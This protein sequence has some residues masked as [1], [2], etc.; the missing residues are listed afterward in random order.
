MCVSVVANIHVKMSHDN[1]VGALTPFSSPRQRILQFLEHFQSTS[2]FSH[3]V[4]V[5]FLHLLH[6]CY[7]WA[8][9][10]SE[11]W[12][13]NLCYLSLHSPERLYAYPTVCGFS[14]LL[15]I[16][17]Y[18]PTLLFFFSAY[19]PFACCL[20]VSHTS[21]SS[22]CSAHSKLHCLWSV[23]GVDYCIPVSELL[24]CTEVMC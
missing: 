15:H 24:N 18:T 11:F 9:D 10:S 7:F 23:Q 22:N 12:H 3:W 1:S 2:D 4:S 13:R 16:T 8:I 14:L 19:F 17:Q 5:V 6:R 20:P 21:V